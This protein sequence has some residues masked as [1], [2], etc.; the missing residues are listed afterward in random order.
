MRRVAAKLRFATDG[1]KSAAERDR[2]TL[3]AHGNTSRALS[4]TPP[5]R[6]FIIVEVGF[7]LRCGV[8]RTRT[9][10]D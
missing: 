9:D 3:E 6:Q 2:S 10:T 1:Y 5:T 8:T 7:M 4:I